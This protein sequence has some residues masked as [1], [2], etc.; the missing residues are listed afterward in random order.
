MRA[1]PVRAAIL[2]AVL[3]MLIALPLCSDMEPPPKKIK[4]PDYEGTL[5]TTSPIISSTSPVHGQ[6]V[7]PNVDIVIQFNESMNTSSFLYEFFSGW[8]PEM[9]W[10][11]E[12]TVC[13]NDTIRGTHAELFG[14]PAEYVFNV[15]YIEDVAG[16]P[17]APGPSPNPWNWSVIVV[18]TETTPADGE[19]NVGLYQDIIVNFSG[20]MNLSPLLTLMITPDPGG[21]IQTW[22][23]GDTTLWLTHVAPFLPCTLH[24]V[25]VY[26]DFFP[27]PSLVPNPWSFTTMCP[28][29]IMSTDPSDGQTDIPLDKTITVTFSKSMNTSSVSCTTVPFIGL[30]PFWDSNDTVLSL[31]HVNP[32]EA[33][34][35]YIV[36]IQG[37]DKEGNDLVAGPVPNPWTFYTGFEEHLLMST[38]PYNGEVDVSLDRSI[39]LEFSRSIDVPTFAW[40]ID[41]YIVLTPYW[42]NDNKTL[43]FT[44]TIDFENSTLYTMGVFGSD[45][46]GYPIPPGPVPNPWSWTTEELPS[47]PPPPPA[48]PKSISASLSGPQLRD[49][50]IAWQLSDDDSPDGNVSRYDIIRGVDAYDNSGLS[51]SYLTSV[52][53]GTSLFVD[54]RAGQDEHSY[55][56]L[57]CAANSNGSTCTSDQAAKFTRPLVSGP[58]LVSIPLVQSNESIERVLQT[59]E[60]DKAWFYDSS[61]QE[62][63]WYMTSKDYR[64]GLWNVYGSTGLWVNVTEDSNLTIAGI[65]P[66]QTT[67]HLYEGWNLVSFPSFNSSYA[68][69][70][71]RMD[72][73]ALH[74][75]GYDPT[76]PYHL[77]VLGDAD[78]LQAGYG[79]WVK[80]QADA[81][82]IVEVS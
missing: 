40:F 39:I 52:P 2:G 24:T 61:S 13:E 9:N 6:V 56:Y 34:T 57:V 29:E 77:R 8:D 20:S 49:V 73:G 54:Q 71:L 32:F 42:T 58:S 51:Y 18:I 38:D 64:R 7:Y 36:D 12:S 80:V 44:H 69:Y 79:Y 60:W 14:S 11:W 15:T 25:G 23:N 81:D 68:M 27:F 76:P 10:T 4:S 17:L 62:W 41:P 48:P 67:I 47:P 75:E 21:W 19:V 55:F 53:K 30:I 28:P 22:V 72:T 35:A 43:W 1:G 33:F 78:V 65:V 37:E 66:A 26:Q 31:L 70:D 46:D 82:W 5:D 16:N 74:V 45:I 50:T 63:K 59:V 3:V